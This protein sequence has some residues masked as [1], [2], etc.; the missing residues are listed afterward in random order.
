MS[1][2]DLQ[3]SYTPA[4]QITSRCGEQRELHLQLQCGSAVPKPQLSVQLS[5]QLS[6]FLSSTPV[7]ADG[8]ALPNPTKLSAIS[9]FNYFHIVYFREFMFLWFTRVFF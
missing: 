9:S 8:S 4:A 5:V 3:P 2:N 6:A 1:A 7:E